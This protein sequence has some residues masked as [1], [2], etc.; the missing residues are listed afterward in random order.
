M[1][2]F[3]DQ[4]IQISTIFKNLVE[5][6]IAQV[7]LL[8]LTKDFEKNYNASFYMDNVLR[9]LK[10]LRKFGGMRFHRL[11]FDDYFLIVLGGL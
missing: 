10:S 9:Q 11:R 6:C 3:A 2:T 7:N 5:M 4:G 8:K 1:N